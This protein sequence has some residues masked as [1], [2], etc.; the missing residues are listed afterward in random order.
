MMKLAAG[1]G[2]SYC[3]TQQLDVC[4]EVCPSYK[5]NMKHEQS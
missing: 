4:G 2:G 5:C 1:S 3:C